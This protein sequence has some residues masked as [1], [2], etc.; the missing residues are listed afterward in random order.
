MPFTVTTSYPSPMILFRRLKEC[1][2]P[3]GRGSL[4]WPLARVFSVRVRTKQVNKYQWTLILSCVSITQIAIFFSST[5]K[6]FVPTLLFFF[7]NHKWKYVCHLVKFAVFL[8]IICS[9][10]Y[11]L[12]ISYYSLVGVLHLF[13]KYRK[14]ET[15]LPA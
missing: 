4:G 2:V 11:S 12:T 13:K 8:E 9:L 15:E 6:M 14:L 3:R 1:L 5:C 10:R 7:H